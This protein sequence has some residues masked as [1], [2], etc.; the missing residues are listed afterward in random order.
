MHEVKR[1]G[2]RTLVG[3]P[4]GKIPVGRLR[5]RWEDNIK[6]DPKAVGWGDLH[7]I[8][9]TLNRDQWRALVNITM[10]LLVV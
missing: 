3:K 8:N 2:Y 6:M 4:K 9:L 1:K 7:W 5:L 10:N